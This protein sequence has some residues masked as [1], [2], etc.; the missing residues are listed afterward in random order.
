M[1]PGPLR[2][3]LRHPSDH[4]LHI[5]IGDVW[6]DL[7]EAFPDRVDE[8]R[9]LVKD[10][11][12]WRTRLEG[13]GRGHACGRCPDKT[14]RPPLRDSWPAAPIPRPVQPCRPDTLGDRSGERPCGYRTPVPPVSGPPYAGPVRDCPAGPA[15][16]PGQPATDAARTGGPDHRSSP[17][18]VCEHLFKYM[19]FY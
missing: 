17:T 10:S 11:L 8:Y 3:G 9:D 16:L 2:D 1:H 15:W 12:I 13:A 7:S 19:I 6:K 5:R 14:A 18:P 4:Q